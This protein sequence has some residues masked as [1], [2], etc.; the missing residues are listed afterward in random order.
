V[1]IKLSNPPGWPPIPERESSGVV[2]GRVT[3]DSPPESYDV[4]LGAKSVTIGSVAVP[5]P[6]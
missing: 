6:A 2:D 3:S 1:F 5:E 4:R